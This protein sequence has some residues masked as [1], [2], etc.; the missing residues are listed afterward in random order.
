MTSTVLC[1]TIKTCLFRFSIYLL[2]LPLQNFIEKK[3]GESLIQHNA[4]VDN[5]PVSVL[6]ISC[7]AAAALGKGCSCALSLSYFQK[8]DEFK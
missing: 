6:D 8:D 5:R 7:A 3:G 1:K 2:L 4:P